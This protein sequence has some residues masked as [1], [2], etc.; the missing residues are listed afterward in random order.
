MFAKCLP[1]KKKK[2]RRSIVHQNKSVKA[3][4]TTVT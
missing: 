4:V 3:C 1:K 2:S